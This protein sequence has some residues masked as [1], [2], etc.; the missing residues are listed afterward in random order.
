MIDQLLFALD[1]TW[2]FLGLLAFIVFWVWFLEKESKPPRH[3]PP[4]E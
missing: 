4:A 3:L 2:P 1:V